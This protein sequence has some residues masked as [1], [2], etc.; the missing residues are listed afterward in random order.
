MFSVH[1]MLEKFENAAFPSFNLCLRKP[2]AGESH[3]YSGIIVFGKHIR[4]S[5]LTRKVSGLNS[6]FEKV[7]VGD[8]LVWTADLTV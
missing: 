2:R 1:A 3:E 4:I 8:G 5:T 6:V 7:G